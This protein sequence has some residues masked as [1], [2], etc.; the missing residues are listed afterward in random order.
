MSFKLIEKEGIFFE[1]IKTG[2]FFTIQ[3]RWCLK[4]EESTSPGIGT[5]N[6]FCLNN[7]SYTF[8]DDDE[9]V[10]RLNLEIKEV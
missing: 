6:S 7:G 3:G 9:P 5:W 2:N 4:L 8:F 10:Y 1:D